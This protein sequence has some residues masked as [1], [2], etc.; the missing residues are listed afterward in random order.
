MV[1]WMLLHPDTDDIIMGYFMRSGHTQKLCCFEGNFGDFP[2]WFP[3]SISL[4]SFSYWIESWNYIVGKML[5]AMQPE[6]E[7]LKMNTERCGWN[8]QSIHFL[9]ALTIPCEWWMLICTACVCVCDQTMRMNF[10]SKISRSSTL[11]DIQTNLCKFCVMSS[12]NCVS[13][14]A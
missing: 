8:S 2:H 6:H 7:P 12:D 4:L 14:Y 13:I 1:K 5:F 3:Y 11:P 9:F 10:P